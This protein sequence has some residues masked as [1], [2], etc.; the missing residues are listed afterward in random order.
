MPPK[1]I[2]RSWNGRRKARAGA[3]PPRPEP[4]LPPW[5][6]FVVQLTS[7]TTS[8][9]GTLAGRVE[10]LGSGRRERFSSGKELLAT[11]LHLLEEA[12]HGGSM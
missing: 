1:Q 6:A 2:Q 10:H 4:E 8:D 9:S 7:D 5:K 12:E 11:L 3:E